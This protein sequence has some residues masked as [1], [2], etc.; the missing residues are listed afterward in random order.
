[1]SYGLRPRIGSLF[2]RLSNFPRRT[3]RAWII[4]PQKQVVNETEQSR[5]SINIQIACAGRGL[6]QSGASRS[7]LN[8]F[9]L[10]HPFSDNTE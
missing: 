4:E 2:Q 5:T 10:F 8:R 3:C 6:G 7:N 9:R 1:M